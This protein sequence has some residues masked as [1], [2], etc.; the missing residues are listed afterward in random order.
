LV[1]WALRSPAYPASR[2]SPIGEPSRESTIQRPSAAPDR[3]RETPPFVPRRGTCLGISPRPL[4]RNHRPALR[5]APAA[6]EPLF[7]V[8]NLDRGAEPGPQQVPINRRPINTPP[9]AVTSEARRSIGRWGLLHAG[10]G[11]LAFAATLIFL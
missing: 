3:K 10:R 11:V 4:D 7:E 5:P 8:A 6:P 1:S 9:R 2:S